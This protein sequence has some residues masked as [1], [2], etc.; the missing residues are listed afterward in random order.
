MKFCYNRHGQGNRKNQHNHELQEDL[1]NVWRKEDGGYLPNFKKGLK[2]RFIIDIT[3]TKDCEPKDCSAYEDEK[4]I[5]VDL[6]YKCLVEHRQE[7]KCSV[8]IET[9]AAYYKTG[10]NVLA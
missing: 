8:M 7:R 3:E 2:Q 5:E 6:I 10:N 9:M 1:N 4:I